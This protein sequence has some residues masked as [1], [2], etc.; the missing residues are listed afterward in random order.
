MDPAEFGFSTIPLEHAPYPAISP[1]TLK[2]TNKGKV[3]VITGAGQ[4]IGAAISESL[5]NSGANVAILDLTVEK[6]AKT[7][8]A[9]QSHDVKVEAYAC[10]VTDEKGV[11][12]TLDKIEEDLGP[13]E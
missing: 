11:I 4:G 3:A 9:C 8:Q 1:E 7:K 10:D 13:I 12:S 2:G 6:L 5:A